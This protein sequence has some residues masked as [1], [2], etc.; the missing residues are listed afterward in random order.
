[1][2]QHQNFESLLREFLSPIIEQ[3]VEKAIAR[4]LPQQTLPQQSFPE[5]MDSKMTA[6]FLHLA[7]GTLYGLAFKRS[8]PHIKRVGR[9]YFRRSELERWLANG[10][11]QMVEEI[12]VEALK[13][14]GKGGRGK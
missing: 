5:Y 11:R 12:Q 3:A 1:M 14:L 6:E 10:R 13:S 9:L 8:I 7:K 4:H 2:E